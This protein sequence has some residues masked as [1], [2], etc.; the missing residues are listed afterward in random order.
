MSGGVGEKRT[1]SFQ[2]IARLVAPYSVMGRRPESPDRG[3]TEPAQSAD[4]EAALVQA[5]REGEPQALERFYR[6][7]VDRVTR[8]IGRLVGPTPDLEDLVQATF[9]ET[10]NSFA[11]FRGEASLGTWVIRIGVNV[12]RHHLRRGVRRQARLELVAEGPDAPAAGA[13]DETFD[14][15]RIAARLHELLDRIAPP[16]RIAFLLHVLEGYSVDEVAALTGSG[17]AAT[18]SRIWWARREV[19]K[20]ARRDP[21]LRELAAAHEDK[22]SH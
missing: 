16:K 11:R 9:I 4:A 5:C 15:H 19:L 7:H 8:V 10:L 17:R 18:K 21:L 22:E 14:D 6:A 3:L 1:H 12:A 20:L 13:A 2:P